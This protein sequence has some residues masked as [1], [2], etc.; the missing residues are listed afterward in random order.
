MAPLTPAQSRL[1]A[2]GA[3]LL[4]PDNRGVFGL[5]R[6][7]QTFRPGPQSFSTWAWRNVQRAKVD[8]RRAE[9]RRK[10]T[11]V[12]VDQKAVE[13]FIVHDGLDTRLMLE[14][15][16]RLQPESMQFLDALYLGCD[17]SQKRLAE[18][19]GVSEAAVS[20]R[21]RDAVRRVGERVKS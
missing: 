6:A 13:A 16:R 5:L 12:A 18:Q 19:R 21:R 8:D 10:H 1:A 7:A 14:D 17:G 2:S 15:L 4:G 3:K 11:F 9:R 20:K